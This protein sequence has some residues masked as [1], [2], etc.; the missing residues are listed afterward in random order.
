MTVSQQVMGCKHSTVINEVA[1]EVTEDDAKDLVEQFYAGLI[2]ER[3]MRKY[4][5]CTI[6]RPETPGQAKA[7][8]HK[9]PDPPESGGGLPACSH[10]IP[11]EVAKTG[12][13][14][15]QFC[16]G[17]QRKVKSQF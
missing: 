3:F 6:Y 8:S 13:E 2:V 7:A 14:G 10:N 12:K 11:Q 5:I 15:K 16:Q 1:G 9:W 4:I 17:E